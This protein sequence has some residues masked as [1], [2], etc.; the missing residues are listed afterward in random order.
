[1]VFCIVQVPQYSG[2]QWSGNDQ[3]I[4]AWLTIEC[5]WLGHEETAVFADFGGGAVSPDFGWNGP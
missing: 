1:M 2:Y 5:G 3:P 4:L